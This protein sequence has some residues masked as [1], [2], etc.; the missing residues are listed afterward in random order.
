MIKLKLDLKYKNQ[1]KIIRSKMKFELNY[2][3]KKY[4]YRRLEGRLPKTCP[5]LFK[6]GRLRQ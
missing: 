6:S 1:I 3:N 4:D 5:R 2:E